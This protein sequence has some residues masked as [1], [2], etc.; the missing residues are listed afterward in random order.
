M[1]DKA[2]EIVELSKKEEVKFID[3]QFTDIFGVTKSVTL[4]T[5]R[6]EEALERGVWFDGSSIQGF[7][8]I[9]NRTCSCSSTR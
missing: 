8:R 4:P 1:N 9:R 3:L 6:L 7:A 5:D 2:R